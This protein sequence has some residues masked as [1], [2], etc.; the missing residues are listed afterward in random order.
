MIQELQD[1]L[2]HK[3]QKAT[4]EL[5]VLLAQKVIKAI[6]V[7]KVLRAIKVLPVQHLLMICLLQNNLKV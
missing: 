5:Q 1:L 3:V 2:V 6:L 7:L 4:Q